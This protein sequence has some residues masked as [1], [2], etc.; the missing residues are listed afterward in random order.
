MYR[1]TFIFTLKL[2]TALLQRLA[3]FYTWNVKQRNDGFD[4]NTF[5]VDR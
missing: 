3:I 5:T 1:Y 2:I 4:Q